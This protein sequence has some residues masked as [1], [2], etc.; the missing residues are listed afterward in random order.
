MARD[1]GEIEEQ[2][3]AVSVELEKTADQLHSIKVV[4]GEVEAT[5]GQNKALFRELRETWREGEMAGH[6]YS[7]EQ[8]A[9]RLEQKAREAFDEE[10][11]LVKQKSNEL[12]QSETELYVRRKGLG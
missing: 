7:V 11:E 1:Q 9:L 3:A 8:E 6:L 2:L 4:E 5:F 12:G 10:K